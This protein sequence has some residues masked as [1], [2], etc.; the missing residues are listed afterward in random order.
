MRILITGANGFVGTHLIAHL[1]KVQ[2]E[3]EILGLVH[4]QA[5]AAAD[6]SLRFWVGDI[7]DEAQ[8]RALIRREHPNQ[9]YHLAGAASGAGQD[10]AAITRTNVDGTRF[11]MTALAEDAPLARSLFISTGYVYG[12]CDPARP[13]REDDP[14]HPIGPYAESKREAEPY[15]RAAG[16]MI[17]RAFN[18]TGPG[19]TT[20]FAVPAFAAQIAAIE[21]GAQPPELRVGNLDAQR[22]FLDVR[23]VV[24]AYHLLMTHGE[25]GQIYNVC[26]GDAI[27]MQSLLESLLQHSSIPITVTPDPARM[28]PSDIAASVGDP[29]KLQAQ[30]GWQPRIPL[31]Q[32]L[33]DVLTWWRA[34]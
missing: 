25:P 22:D 34:Q 33:Q 6:G 24:R 30:T 1:R 16:A 21:R 28:R 2:P 7:T 26:R 3:A 19:Q 5:A 17:A 27:T 32:T 29:A 20:A 8:V 14:L 23:D 11:V 13:A 15:A 31:T 9:V 12:D 4:G 18:H 10:R